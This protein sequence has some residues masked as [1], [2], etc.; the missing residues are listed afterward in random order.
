[1][2][3]V[4]EKKE[5]VLSLTVNLYLDLY[6]AGIDLLRLI[7]LRK[8]SFLLENLGSKSSDVHKVDGLCAVKLLAGINVTL[9]G[10]LELLIFKGNI[11]YGCKEGCMTAMI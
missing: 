10:S 3:F 5:P 9:P 2:G 4:L 1:M 11:I 6:G 7:K 8:L